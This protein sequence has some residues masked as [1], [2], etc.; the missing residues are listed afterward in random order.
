[1]TSTLRGH[2]LALA[3]HEGWEARI[4]MPDLPPPA[5]NHPVVRLAN[6]ALPLTK[7]TYA[8]DVADGLRSGEVVASL[9]EFS[10]SLADRGLYAT[11]GVPELGPED[12]DPRAV[13]RQAPG[14]AGVQRFFSE[15][16]RAFSLYVVARRGDGLDGAMLQLTRQLRGLRVEAR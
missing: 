1:M 7:N 6:F 12:L 14:R 10:P 2:G 4:W 5:E 8:E 11:R 9:A 16:G 15:H 13:Q 3:V